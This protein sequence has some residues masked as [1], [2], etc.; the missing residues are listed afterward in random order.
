MYNIIRIIKEGE[1]VSLKGNREM[2]RAR[3]REGKGRNDATMVILYDI[4]KS[5][6]VNKKEKEKDL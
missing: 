6:K 3:R 2:G 4:F 5:Y 1:V